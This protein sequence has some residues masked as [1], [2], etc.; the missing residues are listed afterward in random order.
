MNIY[1]YE[2]GETQEICPECGVEVSV[3]T[4]GKSDCPKCGHKEILPCSQCKLLDEDKCDWNEETRCS[5]FPK[6]INQ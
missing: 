6:Q 5:A 3:Q 2:E 1:I 4:N